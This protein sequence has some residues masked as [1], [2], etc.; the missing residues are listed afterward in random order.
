M[1]QID[2]KDKKAVVTGGAQGI[3]L[4]IAEL[5]I[6]SG[7]TVSLWDQDQKL[8]NETAT[9]LSSKGKVDAVTVDVSDLDSVKNA[10]IQTKKFMD[11]I[12]ILVC[13]A[14]ISGPNAKLWDYPPEDWQKIMNINKLFD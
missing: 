13:N 3:G 6:D 1:N 14:G 4:A 11:G 12:D 9:R 10:V 5:M 8:V 2:L 7:A